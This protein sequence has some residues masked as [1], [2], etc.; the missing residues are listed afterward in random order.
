MNQDEFRDTLM[1]II[2]NSTVNLGRDTP[3][4]RKFM[5]QIKELIDEYFGKDRERIKPLKLDR[6]NLM[7][8]GKGVHAMTGV[9][10]AKADKDR[11]CH[12]N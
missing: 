4:K 10:S 9:D 5:D 6:S 1:N 12:V 8:I 7:D 2:T 11:G 3:T